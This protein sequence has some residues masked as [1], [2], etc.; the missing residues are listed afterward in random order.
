MTA[1]P[2]PTMIRIVQRLLQYRHLLVTLTQRELSARYRGSVLGFFWSLVNPIMLLAVYSFVFNTI[3]QPR[4]PSVSDYGPYALFL[5]T[6]VIPWI[7]IQ[8]AWLEGTMALLA[9]A[10]LI[11]KATFPAEILPMVSVVANLVQFILALPILALA[12]I[13]TDLVSDTVVSLNWTIVF[14]PLITLLLIPMIGGLT[15]AFSALN[16]HFKDIR[17]ILQNLLTLLFFMT[18]ILYNL[19]TLKGYPLLHFAVARN[20]FTPF[21]V[22][23]QE[24]VF[25]GRP[26]GLH[27]WLEMSIVSLVI[28][29]IGA[30]IFDRLSETLVEAV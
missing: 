30:W 29:C 27:L 17:D 19:G 25:Y 24:S 9:N 5:A 2:D 21:M 23:Y 28:W 18:P 8:T 1:F 3:F 15:L 11:R 14:F 6:G 20:P 7:W 12:F 22:A 10:G 26:P 16:V 13:V 4:D